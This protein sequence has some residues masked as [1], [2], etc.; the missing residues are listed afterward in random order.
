LLRLQGNSR[1]TIDCCIN[2][3][4]INIEVL[5][6]YAQAQGERRSSGRSAQARF[7]VAG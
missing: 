4:I 7:D 2:N 5:K 3:A 6:T 1:P